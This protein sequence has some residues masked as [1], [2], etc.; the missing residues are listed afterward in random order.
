MAKLANHAGIQHGRAVHFA[1]ES[2]Q[3]LL[4]FALLIPILLTLLFGGI[5]VGRMIYSQNAIA[6]AAYEGAYY[7]MLN[8]TDINGIKAEVLDIAVGV[9]LQAG[10]IEVSCEPCYSG[11]SIDVAITYR[12]ES[13][14]TPLVPSFTLYASA[15]YYIQ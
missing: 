14:F 12:F 9:P 4:E 1:H 11:A 15:K 6:H 10:D 13:V 5:E 3:S 7:G 2:G 8:P